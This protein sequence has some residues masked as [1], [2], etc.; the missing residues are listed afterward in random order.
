SVPN[1]GYFVSAKTAASGAIAWEGSGETQNTG[2]QQRVRVVSVSGSQVT[3]AKGISLPT[4]TWRT[5]RSPKAGW[6]TVAQTIHDAGIESMVVRSTAYTTEHLAV[7]AINW[8]TD[9][10]VKGGAV[11]PRTTSWHASNASDY[12]I[13]ITDSRNITVRDSWVDR[14]IG[15]GIYTT[16]SYGIALKTTFDSLVE[17]N[18]LNAVESPL[19]ILTAS[20]GNV[21]AYNYEHYVNDDS[22]EGGFQ[23]HQEG[24]S[25]NLI[26]GNEFIKEWSDMFHGSTVLSTYFR[27]HVTNDG[28]DLA[29]YH[30]WY[31]LIGNVGGATVYKGLATDATKYD[32][33]SPVL[34]RLGYPQQNA[35]NATTNGVAYDPVVWTSV[36]LWGNYIGTGGTRFLA[37]EVPSADPV[38]PNPVPASQVLPSSFYLSTRP[39]WWPTGK[40]WPAVGPDVTGG[41]VSGFG[42]HAYTTPAQDCYTAAGGSLANF[43]PAA[44]YPTNPGP[45]TPTGLRIVP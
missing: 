24:S 28:F 14:M 32:R 42:G 40:P 31:N 41:N 35:S 38:L 19:M 30:R 17:N 45:S 12:G 11:Q 33:W 22:Q 10:W 21:F 27:N 34:F 2:Q 8:A 9:C 29:S 43:N 23:Q 7:V 36:M 13:Y 18:I 26:E 1:N 5:A 25:M 15:G 20:S 4:G 3:I 6:F 39:N 37:A 44:C 16:T